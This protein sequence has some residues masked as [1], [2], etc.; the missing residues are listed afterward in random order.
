MTRLIPTNHS[1][2]PSPEKIPRKRREVQARSEKRDEDTYRSRRKWI[3]QERSILLVNPRA[4]GA[5]RRL[6]GLL[7]PISLSILWAGRSPYSELKSL[8]IRQ[9]W[10]G[11]VDPSTDGFQVSFEL[12]IIEGA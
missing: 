12:V 4:A 8:P 5:Q 3:V 11:S 9:M 7:T 2:F 10:L 1:P 6:Q